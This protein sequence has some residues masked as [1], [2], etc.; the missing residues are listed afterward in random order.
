MHKLFTPFILQIS[1]V[2]SYV[3]LAASSNATMSKVILQKDKPFAEQ[4]TKPNTIYIIKH[5]FDLEGDI[6]DIQDGC[7]LI[8][9]RKGKITNGALRLNNTRLEGK[10]GF[11]N[12]SLSGVCTNEVLYSDLFVLDKT[13]TTDN[14]VEIQSLF[15]VGVQEIHFSKGIYSFSDI[16]VGNVNIYA[17][18]SSFVST[19]AANGYAV[20]NNIF[21]ADKT[22]FFRLYDAIIKGRTEGNPI[23]KKIVLS[24]I[25]L[26]EVDMVEIKCCAFRGI[27]SR[28]FQG[29]LGGLYDYRGVAFS[30]HGCK[31]VLVESC[32]FYD[33]GPSE[34]TWIAPKTGGTWL[35]VENVVLRDNLIH[36][37]IDDYARSS[38]PINV[39]S[40]KVVFE[41]NLLEFQKYAGSAFN[42]QSRVV[43]VHD[44]I[45]RNSYFK[46][47]VDVCEYGDF[48]NDYVEVF[49][50]DF[51]AY[52]SQAV[53]ANS[54]ELIVR[55]NKFEGISAVLA[56]ATYYNPSLG[57]GTCVDY[58]DEKA[59]PNQRVIIERNNCNC[60]LVDTTWISN[61]KIV[62]GG[63]CSGFTIQSISCISDSV[64]IAN[65][66]LFIRSIEGIEKRNHQPILIRN[67]KIIDIQNNYIDSDVP[68][69]GSVRAG[70]IYILVYNRKQGN[71]ARMSEVESVNIVGNKFNIISAHKDLYTIRI[72]DYLDNTVQWKVNN[73]KII[74]NVTLESTQREQIYTTGGQIENLTIEREK[75][76]VNGSPANIRKLKMV[77]H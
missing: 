8:F 7:V 64:Q 54:K 56:Y 11:Q 32:E 26:T 9:K 22:D 39:F 6:V 63:H 27:R 68:A 36:N 73:A 42:L 24:P 1:V 76:D 48:Y 41:G 65:N 17:N 51:S 57:H 21:I 49:N 10:Q 45:V 69:I 52:N 44:N 16:R 53:V 5:H 62:N 67:A 19:I 31:N 60:N 40:D 29:Y 28:C 38:T 37:P 71:D 15:N 3:L 4:I 50:N 59:T 13:G 20:I 30:C 70:A 75:L 12:I 66:N 46:S 61:G 23:I 43:I 47:I 72:S 14:S 74:G 33:L 77:E 34:W 58:A 18:G 25:D 35:D 2:L 55:D